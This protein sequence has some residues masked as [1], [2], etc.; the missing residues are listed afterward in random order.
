MFEVPKPRRFHYE[1]R[2]YDPEK[3]RWEAL[4]KKHAIQQE[5]EE[6]AKDGTESG[7]ELDY[8]ER[9]V[10]SIDREQ[11]QQAANLSWR[12][13]FRRREMPQFSYKP[14]FNGENTTETTK[15]SEEVTL[16]EK[17]RQPKRQIKIRRRFDISDT[18]YMKPVSGTKI[19][20]YGFLAF[21]LLSLI[22][23]L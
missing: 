6:A 10:R 7:S 15:S 20:L 13:L 1:P 8:F 9:R 16:S 11:R 18:N 2:F 23:G 21:L 14:R 12:D 3:E 22:L 5:M 4:K 19:I 17:Y